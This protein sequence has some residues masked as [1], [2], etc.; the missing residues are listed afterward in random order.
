MLQEA[1]VAAAEPQATA[2][3]TDHSTQITNQTLTNVQEAEEVEANRKLRAKEEGD[4]D[5]KQQ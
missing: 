1:E 5:C 2:L 3:H 4:V